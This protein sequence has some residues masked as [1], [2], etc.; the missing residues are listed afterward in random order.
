ME[1]KTESNDSKKF[2]I[3]KQ[4]VAII[5]LCFSIIGVIL[6]LRAIEYFSLIC[7]L[8]AVVMGIVVFVKKLAGKIIAGVAILAGLVGIVFGAQVTISAMVA[9][10]GWGEEVVFSYD[11]G[12]ESDS[13]NCV[14]LESSSQDDSS[15]I[16]EYAEKLRACVEEKGVDPDIDYEDLADSEKEV[17]NECYRTVRM[18]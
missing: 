9:T 15:K 4:I 2:S 13:A 14:E 3:T 18:N 1:D 10:F 16:D 11:C 6:A 5:A 12:S 17:Q 8:I 7:A